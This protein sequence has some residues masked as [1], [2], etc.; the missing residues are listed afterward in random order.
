MFAFVWAIL[1]STLYNWHISGLE[2][3]VFSKLLHKCK[4]RFSQSDNIVTVRNYMEWCYFCSLVH[5][6]QWWWEGGKLNCLWEKWIYCRWRQKKPT[7]IMS[8]LFR[9]PAQVQ[10]YSPTTTFK[11][12]CTDGCQI[13]F[14]ATMGEVGAETVCKSL[15]GKSQNHTKGLYENYLTSPPN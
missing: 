13:H 5:T 12:W 11:H 9:I 3:F 2:Q 14:T 6:V 7:W 1:V 10:C 8:P 15:G 4:D